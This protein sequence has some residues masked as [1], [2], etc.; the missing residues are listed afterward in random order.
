[1]KIKHGLIAAASLLAS[2]ALYAAAPQAATAPPA[3]T[4]APALPKSSVPEFKQADTNHDGK[5][6]WAEA[7]AVG[8]PEKIFKQDDF[9]H[10]GELNETEWMFV[11]LDMTDFNAPAPATAG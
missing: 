6:S 4:A 8:V 5:I 3:V 1:M 10:N 2:A 11:R 9:D 7:R